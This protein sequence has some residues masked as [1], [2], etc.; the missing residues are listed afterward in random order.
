MEDKNEVSNINNDSTIT[1]ELGDIIEIESPRNLEYHET[2]NFIYY[3]DDK[4]IEATNVSSMKNI[5]LNLNEFGNLTDES[6]EK[7]TLLDRSNEKGYARQ[8]NLFPSQWINIHFSGDMPAIIT[9][10]ITNLEE[11]MIEIITYPEMETIYINFE[12]HG[13]PKHIPIE[14]IVIREKPASLTSV[15]SLSLL[16]DSTLEGEDVEIDQPIMEFTDNGESVIDTPIDQPA[17]KDIKSVLHELYTDANTITF[18]EELAEIP[19]LVEVPENEQRYS[20]DVQVNDMMD[21]LLSTIPNSQRNKQVLDNIHM[22]ITRYV[23][24]RKEF[25]KF[26][27]NNNVYDKKVQGAYY[28]PLVDKLYNLNYN[29]KWLLPVVSNKKKIHNESIL[30]INASDVS[31]EN[32]TK[33]ASKVVD[34]I[35]SYYSKGTNDQL[36]SIEYLEKMTNRFN[37]PFEEPTVKTDCIS[38]KEVMNAIDAVVD[39]LNDFHSTVYAESGIKRTRFLIQRYSLGS[40]KIKEDILKSGKKKYSQTQIVDNDKM[41]V[42][43]FLMLPKSAIEF[44]KIDLPTTSMLERSNLHQNYLLLFKLFGKNPKITT[45]VINDLSKELDYENFEAS[46]KQDLFD[47][48][49]EF[50]VNADVAES[51]EYM[52][53]NERFL[54]FLEIIIPKTRTLIKLY[55]KHINYKLSFVGIIGR[56]EPF[57]IYNKDV[58]YKQYME[59]RYFIKERIKELKIDIAN[60]S[61]KYNAISN[62]RYNVLTGVND[63]LKILTEQDNLD[64]SFF[65]TYKFLTKDKI[66]SKLGTSEILSNMLSTDNAELYTTIMSSIL[67]RLNSPDNIMA[68]IDQ[69]E[70][71]DFDEIDKMKPDDCG[72]R[73][74][75]NKYTNIDDLKSDNNREIYFDEELDDTPYQI[76]DRYQNEQETMSSE[77]FFIFL[78]ENLVQRHEVPAEN[79]QE[80]AKTLIAKKRKVEEGH[81]AILDMS[82]THIDSELIDKT[83]DEQTQD[84]QLQYYRRVKDNWVRDNTVSE[85]AFVD[86]NTLFCNI[87][88]NCNKNNKNKICET[89][90]QTK[91]RIK[92]ANAELSKRELGQRYQLSIQELEK[93]LSKE[94]VSKMKKIK[95]NDILNE[96][97]L[98]RANNLA[99]EIGKHANKNDLFESPHIKLRDLILGQTDFSKKQSDICKFVEKYCRDPLSD[100]LNEDSHW[101]YCKETNTKL[102]PFSLY[103]LAVAYSTGQDYLLELHKVCK[104]YGMESDDGDAIV[105]KYSGYIL[106]QKDLSTEEGYDITGRKVS[107]RDILEQDLGIVME[108]QIKKKNKIFASPQLEI[109]YNVANSICNNI[110]IPFEIIESNV[111]RFSNIVMEKNILSESVY[112]RKVAAAKKKG[113][114]Q[115]YKNEATLTIIG[116]IIL[117]S[118]QTTIPSLKPKKTFPTC[119]KSLSGY[120]MTGTEDISGIE[121]MSCV[122][123]KMKSSIDPWN[124]LRGMKQEKLSNRMTDIITNNILT[125]N[126]IN[127]LYINKKEYLL[128]VPEVN[129]PD[130]HKIQKWFHFMPPVVPIKIINSLRNVTVEY[131]K[132]MLEKIKKGDARQYDYINMIKSKNLH[133]SFAVIETINDIVSEKD[134]LLKTAS[135]IPFLE[136]ACCNEN[137]K[138]TN[139]VIYFNNENGNIKSYLQRITKNA[140]TVSDIHN[141]TKARFFNH[142][143]NTGLTYPEVPKG[144]L[145]ENVY[146]AFIHYCNYD[147]NLPVPMYLQSVCNIIPEGYNNKADIS[148]KIDFLKRNNRRFSVNQ[149]HQLMTLV[150]QQ[151]MIE[152][153]NGIVNNQVSMLKDMI[154]HFDNTNSELIEEP[155]R[156]LIKDVLNTYESN[157]MYE[158]ASAELDN[159][160]NYL[161]IANRNMYKDIMQFFDTNAN[162]MTTREFNKIAEFLLYIDKWESDGDINM[163]QTVSQFIKNMVLHITKIYPTIIS[164]N[165]DFYK[166][167]C[168]HWGF[169]ENHNKDVLE[170]INKY[171]KNIEK[172]KGD[173]VIKKMLLEIKDKLID[174]PLLLDSIPFVSDISKKYIDDDQNEIIINFHSLFNEKTYYELLKFTL[175][176][177]LTEYVVSSGD[178]DLLRTEIHNIR[179]AQRAYNENLDDLTNY[180]ESVN[181]SINENNK[182]IIDELEESEIIVDTPE[183][184]KSRIANLLIMY[185]NV[186]LNN[187]SAINM[188]YESIM[189]KVNRSKEREKRSIIDRLGKMSKEERKVEE[190]FKMYKLGRWN[191][192]LQKGLVSYDKNTYDRERDELITQLA[193]DEETGQYEV[194]SEMRREVFELDKEEEEQQNDF[195]E[196]EANN[197]SGLDEDYM[198]GV[199]YEEDNDDDYE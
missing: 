127:E 146:Q 192:G 9:G 16:K 12:Y 1:L 103:K 124:S 130:E 121:Y 73:F 53:E 133:H 155:L 198:D 195:Y 64:E 139:P 15:S 22:L 132:D 31:Y 36:T 63:L 152:I 84:K 108:E 39:N 186:E 95:K 2:T 50:V 77:T 107:T 65:D 163:L 92:N 3:I 21:E 167:V 89:L 101:Y 67:I 136:N 175:Y 87:T 46:T 193:G 99:Y 153:P 141:L 105:D 160:T 114:Y 158:T 100:N 78:V 164:N 165:A 183:D 7:I 85:E 131:K 98:Y 135:Q 24:L 5:Q 188:S 196:Q 38:N 90:D 119:I 128:L 27:E 151:N 30:D 26:D 176:R 47:G 197:I 169:S 48:I 159:L 194:V 170:F 173:K 28:K 145:E 60:K 113:D 174:L 179:Q 125:N 76:V 52:N 14:K 191:V 34:I 58:S 49:N 161:I 18:G 44:S 166:K 35:N 29:L 19:Q 143:K 45:H 111:M 154:D 190:L 142:T 25:S 79:A 88:D 185:L 157:K 11:D 23:Q 177:T 81:Y 116:A 123:I 91:I 181:T 150:H 4:V 134:N 118:I 43:S 59:I 144:Y 122:L 55:R 96:I 33:E 117:I 106:K 56:L 93:K 140:K 199:Y 187:K 102:F 168:K 162:T 180:T 80:T 70:I 83:E 126:E 6:I 61:S 41:C 112:D 51:M 66:N 178:P 147:K 54:K 57:M 156:K 8:N 171:Y 97:A 120:P 72:R 42:K 37:T 86:N 109:I 148:E 68:V 182:N 115:K 75:S 74:L 172:F 17:D 10:Q 69:P 62:I 149:L 138:L 94:I 20:I 13:I 184:L 32:M 110:D 82:P 189:K 40:S 71:K 104:D 129:I 137:L